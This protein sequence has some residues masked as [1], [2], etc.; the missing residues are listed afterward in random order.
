[1]PLRSFIF[2]TLCQP[3]SVPYCCFCC[4][5]LHNVFVASFLVKFGQNREIKSQVGGRCW[6]R[7]VW[8][9]QP[10]DA[11]QSCLNRCILWGSGLFAKQ[12]GVSRKSILTVYSLSSCLFSSLQHWRYA[13]LVPLLQ[14]HIHKHIHTVSISEGPW[15]ACPSAVAG[16][17]TKIFPVTL[18]EWG[19]GGKQ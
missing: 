16:H 13:L 15:A 12:V 17:C 7:H 11:A 14:S 9:H 5:N 8:Q 3:Y 2:E 1:M 6:S 18:W 10:S 4:K 19:G